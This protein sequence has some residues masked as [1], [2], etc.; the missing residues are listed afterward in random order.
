MRIFPTFANEEEM[1]AM[2]INQSIGHCPKQGDCYNLFP[3]RFGYCMHNR[4]DLSKCYE[5]NEAAKIRKETRMPPYCPFEGNCYNET[6]N[7]NGACT[8]DTDDVFECFV[9]K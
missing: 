5:S 8:S 4:D 3:N 9:K 7:R 1:E 2:R 6:L